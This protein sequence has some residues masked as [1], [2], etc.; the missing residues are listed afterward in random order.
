MEK[1]TVCLLMQVTQVNESMERE[2]QQSLELTQKQ[3]SSSNIGEKSK[4]KDNW[5]EN[6]LQTLI[7]AVN[8]FPAGTNARYT[9][10]LQFG[11]Q[12][13]LINFLNIL[14]IT[15]SVFQKTR[16]NCNRCRTILP[17]CNKES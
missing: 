6:E 11:Y 14:I 13:S 3:S 4:A 10:L 12:P 7:K 8:L 1:Y 16:I 15:L 17:C 5:S 2:K 9:V